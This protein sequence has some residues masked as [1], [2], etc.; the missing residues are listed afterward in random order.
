M[1]LVNWPGTSPSGI[2]YPSSET[3]DGGGEEGSWEESSAEK[4]FIGVFSMPFISERTDLMVEV[5]PPSTISCHWEKSW[6]IRQEEKFWTNLIPQSLGIKSWN[7]THWDILNKSTMMFIEYLLIYT[8]N[9][10]FSFLVFMLQN[11]FLLVHVYK[12]V[13]FRDSYLTTCFLESFFFILYMYLNVLA[14]T[15][16]YMHLNYS[17]SKIQVK[18]MHV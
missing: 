14:Y 1:T 15:I 10:F 13:Q 3:G 18:Y 16:I 4:A 11:R 12:T 7:I 9:I 6:K 8:V 17:F 2:E 5:E